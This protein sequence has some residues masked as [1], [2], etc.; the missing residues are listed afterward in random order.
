[1]SVTFTGF[2]LY[3]YMPPHSIHMTYYIFML[4]L[5]MVL[6]QASIKSIYA[7]HGSTT[8]PPAIQ[9]LKHSLPTPMTLLL[10]PRMKM[11]VS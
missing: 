11:L 2:N 6:D 1:M 5:R 4:I 8:L 10:Y 3:V 7:A 9:L